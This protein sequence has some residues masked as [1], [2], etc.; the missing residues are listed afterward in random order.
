VTLSKCKIAWASFARAIGA[1][2]DTR[3]SITTPP[4]FTPQISELVTSYCGLLG[5]FGKILFTLFDALSL[6]LQ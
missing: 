6:I 1:R 4:A 2:V 5:L 3:L